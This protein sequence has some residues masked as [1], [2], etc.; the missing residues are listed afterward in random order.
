MNKPRVKLIPDKNVKDVILPSIISFE[1]NLLN[2]SLPD[3]AFEIGDLFDVIMEEDNK[4]KFMRATLESLNTDEALLGVKD[5]R[6]AIKREYERISLIF[7]V[8]GFDFPSQTANISAG[9]M[10]LRAQKSVEPN[11]V[12]NLEIDYI[13]K[14][15]PVKYEVLRVNKD[16]NNFLISGRFVNLEKEIKAFIIQQNLKNKIFGLRSSPLKTK[17]GDE[18]E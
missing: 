10:Q 6:F 18:N 7:D 4:L 9:G 14:K 8:E 15:I 1:D 12:Y 13:S 2:I 11:K 5:I 3:S 17:L 16:R